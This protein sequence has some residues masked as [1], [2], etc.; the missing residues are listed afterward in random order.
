ME[1]FDKQIDIAKKLGA[2]EED[3]EPL[4]WNLFYNPLKRLEKFD[5][6]IESVEIMT[7]EDMRNLPPSD[8]ETRRGPSR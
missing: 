7:Q 6:I 2:T 4:L 5:D 1:V 3:F 8:D